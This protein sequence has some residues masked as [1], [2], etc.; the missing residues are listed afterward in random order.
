MIKSL[1]SILIGTIALLGV[2]LGVTAVIGLTLP[3]S[4][5]VARSARFAA[6]PSVVFSAISDVSSYADWR[7]DVDR[8]EVLPDDGEGLRF[9]EYSGNDAV[10]FRVEESSSPSRFKVRVDD[11]SLPFSGTW[12]FLLQPFEKGTS[13][14]I[15]EDGAVSNPVFRVIATLLSPPTDSMDRYLHDLSAISN[16]GGRH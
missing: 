12:T 3:E 5:H 8:V 10:T 2:V 15:T 6:P 7:S 16:L 11:T 9:V 4:H 13:L 14:T 1:T